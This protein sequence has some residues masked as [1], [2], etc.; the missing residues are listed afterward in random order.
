[1]IQ[2]PAKALAPISQTIREHPLE[3]AVTAVGGGIAAY[4]VARILTPPTRLKE[5]KKRHGKKKKAK[6]RHDP[7]ADILSALIPLALPHITRYL[8]R[9]MGASRDGSH[10]KTP[11]QE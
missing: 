6:R 5:D 7:V 8:E 3:A 11:S 4:G 1:M 9:Y 2:A 10:D